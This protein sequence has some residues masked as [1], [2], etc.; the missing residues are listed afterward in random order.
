MEAGGRANERDTVSSSFLSTLRKPVLHKEYRFDD[1]ILHIVHKGERTGTPANC[2]RGSFRHRRTQI[3]RIDL[4][5]EPLSE[6][7]EFDKIRRPSG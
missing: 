1:H 5:R 7:N 2:G 4:S 6:T 3:S